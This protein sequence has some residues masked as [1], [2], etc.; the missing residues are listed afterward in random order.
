MIVNTLRIIPFILLLGIVQPANA[1]LVWSVTGTIGTAVSSDSEM[2]AGATVQIDL[3]VPTDPAEYQELFSNVVAPANLGSTSIT[4][5]GSA[6]NNG[7]YAPSF[8][9]GGTSLNFAPNSFGGGSAQIVS[10]GSWGGRI[11]VWTNPTIWKSQHRFHCQSLY[12]RQ[13]SVGAFPDWGRTSWLVRRIGFHPGIW[14]NGDLQ[15]HRAVV[16]NCSRAIRI[17]ARRFSFGRGECLL[18]STSNEYYSLAFRRSL[19]FARHRS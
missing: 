14:F 16:F 11:T 12:R 10:D 8:Y 1:M 13:S 15:W 6:T 9:F 5:S 7:T 19:G 4:I 2:L 3:N 17:L 18:S